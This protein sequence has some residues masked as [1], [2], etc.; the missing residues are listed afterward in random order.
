MKRL[1][2]LFVAITAIVVGFDSCKNNLETMTVT[3]DTAPSAAKAHP[4]PSPTP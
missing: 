3:P 2:L 1:I 4:S